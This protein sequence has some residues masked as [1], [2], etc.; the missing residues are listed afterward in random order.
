MLHFPHSTCK[1]LRLLRIHPTLYRK[2]QCQQTPSRCDFL[3]YN[4]RTNRTFEIIVYITS[5]EVFHMTQKTRY[6][7]EFVNVRLDAN[8]RPI[9]EQWVVDN[10]PEL[11]TMIE[12]LVSDGYKLSLNLDTR[13][14]CFICAFTG[15][16][17]NRENRGLCMTSRASTAM[18][19]LWVGLY[20][21]YVVCDGGSWG[22][23][24]QSAA[25]W[26]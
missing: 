6:G 15:T 19:A 24:E 25:D 2:P 7:T 5:W 22:K 21:H 11:G 13:H 9:V 10:E 20:K 12:A 17:E 8:S 14:D 23:P 16:D 3:A 4:N 1:T 18:E 26:G